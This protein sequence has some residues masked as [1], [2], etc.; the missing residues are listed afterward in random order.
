VPF[1]AAANQAIT[2]SSTVSGGTQPYTY[3]W[4]FN[5]DGIT[6]CT[7]A[8]CSA[9]YPA[10]YNGAVVLTVTSAGGCASTLVI[11]DG[12]AACQPIP[13]SFT[14]SPA[15]PV[16]GQPVTFTSS[17]SGGTAPYTYEWDFNGDGITDCTDA[18][19][20]TTYPAVFTGNVVLRVTDRY[21]CRADVY[22]AQ[23]TVAAAPPASG[24][25]GGGGGCFLSVAAADDSKEFAAG[26]LY[27][28][29]AGVVLAVFRL[30]RRQ[31]SITI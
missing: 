18:A 26:I 31:A 10:A 14:F 11:A 24:G 29:P 16:A 3:A 6:D 8:V 22:T 25:G 1:P 28:V 27:L 15:A 13:A 20:T 23:V 21:G 19:C 4:D 2:F 12:W 17:V 7:D 5:G 9:T 30:R